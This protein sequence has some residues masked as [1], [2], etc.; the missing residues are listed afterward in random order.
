VGVAQDALAKAED[1]GAVAPDQ[2]LKRG[3]VAAADE[4]RQELGVR[5]RAT[6][7]AADNPAQL[8][9]NSAQ[10]SAGHGLAFL[11]GPGLKS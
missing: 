11:R 7:P 2:H 5:Q 1:H 4:V 3:L 6:V 8:A 10:L 9:D